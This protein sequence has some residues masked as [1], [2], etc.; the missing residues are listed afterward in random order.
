[1]CFL[2]EIEKIKKWKKKLTLNKLE[3]EN[4]FYLRVKKTYK[5]YLNSIKGLVECVRF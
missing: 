3:K 2:L 5:I 1:M 4:K